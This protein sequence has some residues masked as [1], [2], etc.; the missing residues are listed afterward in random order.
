MPNATRIKWEH[1]GFIDYPN[2][3]LYPYRDKY[4]PRCEKWYLTGWHKSARITELNK[5]LPI[6]E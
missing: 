3:D 2:C 4:G 5:Q 1:R 6:E